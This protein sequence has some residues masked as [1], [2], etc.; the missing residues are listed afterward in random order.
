[1]AGLTIQELRLSPTAE[2]A[3]LLVKQAH[4]DAVF[5]SGRRD[6]MDQARV[7]A[8]NAIQYGPSW[9]SDTYRN[10]RMVAVLMT[11]M[12][13]HREACSDY[14]VLTRGFYDQ[15]QEHFA[16]DFN[17]MAHVRGDAFDIQ[18]PRLK[19]GLFDK[20]TADRIMST[21]RSLPQHGIPLDWVTDQEGKLKV[22]HAQFKAQPVSVPV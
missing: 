1:M 13:E 10:R 7:M 5:T 11:Y 8:Q 4:P 14:K 3:A 15:L 20:P 22:I 18:Y 6:L 12:E 19:N 21:I 16:E 9:I 17:K 2:K